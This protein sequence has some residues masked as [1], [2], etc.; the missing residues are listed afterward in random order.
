METY[1]G[2]EVDAVY[3]LTFTAEDLQELERARNRPIT[4]DEDCPEV[5]PE[6]AVRFR[7]VNPRNTEAE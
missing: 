2:I 6:Q 4:F 7:R 1:N 5:T 3:D